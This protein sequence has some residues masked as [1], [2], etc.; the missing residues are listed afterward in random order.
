MNP[1]NRGKL[2]IAGED[3]KNYNINFSSS[4]VILGCDSISCGSAFMNA[5][6]SFSGT[7]PRQ[8]CNDDIYINGSLYVNQNQKHGIYKGTYDI[9]VSYD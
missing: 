8:C 1:G 7:N 5:N 2:S 6:L 9:T 4:S 3:G